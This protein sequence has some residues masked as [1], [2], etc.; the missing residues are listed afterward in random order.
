V[1]TWPA[2]KQRKPVIE[3]R[4]QGW[5]IPAALQQC[6]LS[7]EKASDSSFICRALGRLAR[8]R[9][10]GSL[11]AIIVH[12]FQRT[13]GSGLVG[14]AAGGPPIGLVA[15]YPA[16]KRNVYDLPAPRGTIWQKA[17]C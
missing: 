12:Y 1:L 9:F 6:L 17:L 7:S 5:T 10:L 16:F 11:S 8:A 3:Q 4:T 2:T 13:I 15:R 14:A